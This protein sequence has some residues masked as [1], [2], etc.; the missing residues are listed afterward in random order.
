M[1]SCDSC[2]QIICEHKQFRTI[3]LRY[4]TKWVT[5]EPIKKIQMTKEEANDF[6]INNIFPVF[7]ISEISS[8]LRKQFVDLFKKNG[9][10]PKSDLEILVEETEKMKTEYKDSESPY[11]LFNQ[12]FATIQA[13][14]KDHP[15]FKNK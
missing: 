13:L 7:P 10:I 4:C 9:V 8:E 15:E 1:E 5:N 2:G 12:M 3:G 14:K 6:I 11:F